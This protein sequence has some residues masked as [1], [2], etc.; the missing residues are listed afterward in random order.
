MSYFYG[1]PGNYLEGS[2]QCLNRANLAGKSLA[3][4]RMMRNE[5]FARHGYIFKSHDLK[6]HFH[7][8]GWYEEKH[9]DVSKLL[10]EVEVRNIQLIQKFEK[11]LLG[12]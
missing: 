9:T 5:I 3:E 10:T 4:L 12:N 6:N 8:C 7:Q 2:V 1:I 11:A